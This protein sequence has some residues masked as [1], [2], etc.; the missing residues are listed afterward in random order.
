MT[1]SEGSQRARALAEFGQ[2]LHEIASALDEMVDESIGEW[3]EGASIEF[4]VESDASQP[5]DPVATK[6]VA[7]RV[8][9][10]SAAANL[11]DRV[12]DPENE[13]EVGVRGQLLGL[14]AQVCLDLILLAAQSDCAE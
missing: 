2:E 5:I 13:R 10:V 14:R 7:E 1:K 9:A 8:I 4:E 12:H 6:A 11:L 3:L